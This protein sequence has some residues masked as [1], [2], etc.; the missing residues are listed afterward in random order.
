VLLNKQHLNRKKILKTSL[1]ILQVHFGFLKGIYIKWASFIIASG[2]K[3][4]FLTGF[5]SV[6]IYPIPRRFIHHRQL[7]ANQI[8]FTKQ[9]TSGSNIFQLQTL[10]G[11]GKKAMAL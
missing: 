8:H 9:L 5:V 4:F 2:W 10:R 6:C 1:D 3:K 11:I 7:K